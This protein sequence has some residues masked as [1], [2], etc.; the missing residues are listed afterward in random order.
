MEMP[1]AIAAL[2]AVVL[3]Q[4]DIRASDLSGKVARDRDLPAEKMPPANIVS[5]GVRHFCD[6][7]LKQPFN[8]M[9]KAAERYCNE[10]GIPLLKGWAI[11]KERAV[12]L[13]KALRE[14]GE[15]YRGEA[16]RLQ[17]ILDNAYQDWEEANPGWEALLQRDR[18]TPAE[19]RGRYRFRH[20]MYRLRPAVDD[21]DDP[22]N[23]GLGVAR[24]SLMEAILDDVANQA[25]DM[26]EKVFVGKAQVTGRAAATVGVMAAKLQG[27]AMVDPLVTPVATM[28]AEVIASIGTTNSKL[29]QTETSAL[30]GLLTLMSD[31]VKLRNHGARYYEGDVTLDE[32]VETGNV[33]VDPVTDLF[34]ETAFDINQP[35]MVVQQPPRPVATAHN[36]AAVLI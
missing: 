27:F 28:I 30:R 26:L 7:A 21:L 10:V 15:K 1:S 9:R 36:V 24:G 2:D 34:G 22:L 32:V 5:A 35:A 12:A 33:A 18:P 3:V 17:A 13:D 4:L 25:T 23:E 8:T 20:M 11:P 6:P 14:L 16:D 29:S 19:V 31:P